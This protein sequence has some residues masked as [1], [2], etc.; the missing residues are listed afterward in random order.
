M[1]GI[2]LGNFKFSVGALVAI[3]AVVAVLAGGLWW[4]TTNNTVTNTGNA[5][6]A[7]LNSQYVANQESLSTCIVKIRET[8]SV[9]GA[10][11]DKFESVLVEAV[12]GRYDGRAANPGQM[13]S[14][15]VEQY[16]DLAPLERSFKDV[17]TVVVGCRNDYSG[18]QK[19]LLDR[20]RDYDTWRTGSWTVRTFGSEFPSNNLIAR[21]GSGAPARGQD[22]A[23]QMWQIVQVQDSVTAYETGVLVP[24][25][26]FGKGKK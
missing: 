2:Q 24:E 7:A 3:V 8:S 11:A 17:F 12:K 6:E 5:K 18:M 4:F 22:A 19:Q 14:A 25:D 20:L 26:P 1:S 9:T 13:F 16:P 10:M 23:D 15:V 21:I